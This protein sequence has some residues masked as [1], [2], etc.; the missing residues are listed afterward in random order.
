MQLHLQR[1]ETRG[2]T[3]RGFEFVLMQG[4][5]LQI[6]KLFQGIMLKDMQ[7]YI[8]ESEIFR[9]NQPVQNG[10]TLIDS[11]IKEHV[12]IPNSWIHN[13]VLYLYP[14]SAT[15][16]AIRTYKDLLDSDCELVLLVYD[17]SYVE[18]YVKDSDLLKQLLNNVAQMPVVNLD[19]KTDQTDLRSEFF[20]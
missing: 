1:H 2:F 17:M 10:T 6:S 4:K 8:S 14:S 19:I 12:E 16:S 7:I 13:L 3:M 18:I 11:M 5:S 20:I 15:A 9:N